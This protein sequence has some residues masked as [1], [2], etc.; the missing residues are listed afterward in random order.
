LFGFKDGDSSI[1]LEI[2][3]EYIR[4]GRGFFKFTPTDISKTYDSRVIDKLIY[5]LTGHRITPEYRTYTKNVNG[6]NNT[7]FN[8]FA[9]AIAI[10]VLG[11][12]QNGDIQPFS[13]HNILDR[14]NGVLYF[15]KALL[16]NQLET[17]AKIAALVAGSE[18]ANTVKD[19]NG[20][21]LP[22]NGLT[23][24]AYETGEFLERHK[25]RGIFMYNLGALNPGLYGPPVIREG[26]TISGR[27][28]KTKGLNVREL[29]ESSIIFDYLNEL[30]KG[31]IYLQP[32]VNADKTKTLLPE[33][34]INGVLKFNDAGVRYN[35]KDLLESVAKGNGDYATRQ[36]LSAISKLE[37]ALM[38]LRNG[39]YSE[40]EDDLVVKYNF[41]LKPGVGFKTLQDVDNYLT[42]HPIELSELRKKFRKVNIE[43]VEEHTA[44]GVKAKK[45]TYARINETLLNKLKTFNGDPNNERYQ[46]R[47]DRSKRRFAYDLISDGL[48][49][50]RYISKGGLI[51]HNYLKQSNGSSW[52][53]SRSNNIIFAK[54]KIGDSWIN[55]T[56]E[57][58]D[59]LLDPANKDVKI[60][61]VLE[62]YFYAN[63][64]L[65]DEYNVASIGV[66]YSHANKNTKGDRER[67]DF[68][69]TEWE[70]FSEASRWV[71][72][73]KRNVIPG[74]SL[75]PLLQY[76]P[77]GVAEF[78]KVSAMEDID[79]A[80]FSIFARK[81]K[82]DSMD[83]CGLGNIW[84][85]LLEKNSLADAAPGGY[86]LKT[87]GWDLDEH[88][89]PMMLKWAVY[90]ITNERRIKGFA[91]KVNVEALYK[92]MNNIQFDKFIDFISYFNKYASNGFYFTNLN[93]M[94]RIHVVDVGSITDEKTNKRMFYRIADVDG[95]RFYLDKYNNLYDGLDN[96]PLDGLNINT[97]YDIDQFF[98]G[99]LSEK[100]DENGF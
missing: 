52:I 86:D 20:H 25:D 84:E 21:N 79:A 46:K 2:S 34:D 48:R 70:E 83:G 81:D 88:G 63:A 53:D 24:L 7:P 71:S 67:L 35:L 99:A 51:I 17:P 54:V 59:L 19:V 61:P 28:K 68:D 33:I 26:I 90:G 97:I 89:I 85:I 98:G 12:V 27:G 74:A 5:D 13:S 55:I 32:T 73:V 91:S 72:S 23:S 30:A 39:R 22:T 100:Q 3:Y 60:N 16:F 31:I 76:K 87:I 9:G 40:I 56:K 57:N 78:I 80:T 37:N 49:L 41:V 95:Q 18:T 44:I 58:T 6:E 1:N 96:I 45:L 8:D 43:F 64:I 4:K 36:E 69:E 62:S 77:D 92:R 75:H 42:K 93:T 14:T 66:D 15:H 94:Q 47:I 38:I 82:N 50:N 29:Y 10:A 65:A 11:A